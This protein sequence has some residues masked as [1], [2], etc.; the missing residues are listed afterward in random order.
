VAYTVSTPVEETNGSLTETWLVQADGGGEPVRVRHRGEDVSDPRWT[1]DGRLRVTQRDTAWLLDPDRLDA[2][3]VRDEGR[4]PEGVL[5]PDGR[6]RAVVRDVEGTSLAGPVPGAVRVAPEP[7]TLR[8]QADGL[9]R[10]GAVRP[11]P[12]TD[13]QR[14]HEER[15]RGHALD[16]YPFLQDGRPSPSRIPGPGPRRRSS[17]SRWTGGGE[18]GSS[19]AWGSA[20]PT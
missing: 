15:F 7:G 4:A 19:P 12:L 10:A 1:E 13:F 8:S 5:S 14:R 16:W 6:W 18:R 17:W 3:A 9:G 11:T 2:P 20:P